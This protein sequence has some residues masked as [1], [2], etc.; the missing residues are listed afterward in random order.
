MKY[1]PGTLVTPLPEHPAVFRVT[2]PPVGERY[3]DLEPTNLDAEL[4][5]ARWML[6]T[7]ADRFTP[8]SKHLHEYPRQ[9][10]GR[11]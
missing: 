9:D 2:A 1:P 11:A 7:G 4:Y 6:L 3:C 8:K 10:G 5:A